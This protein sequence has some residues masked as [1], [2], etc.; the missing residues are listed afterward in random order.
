MHMRM[1]MYMCTYFTYVCMCICMLCMWDFFR[2]RKREYRIIIDERVRYKT[3]AKA[4]AFK[5]SR[6][7]CARTANRTNH[8]STTPLLY[9]HTQLTGHSV[10]SLVCH[11]VSA[12]SFQPEVTVRRV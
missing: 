11:S 7:T 8:T 12:F 5:R 9:T 4:L 10:W 6:N 3:K 2:E 1:H